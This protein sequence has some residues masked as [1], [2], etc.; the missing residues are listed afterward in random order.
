MVASYLGSYRILT[1]YFGYTQ[2]TVALTLD[3]AYTAVKKVHI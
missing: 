3:N 1:T 2:D